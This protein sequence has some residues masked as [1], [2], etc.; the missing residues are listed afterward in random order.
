MG[1]ALAPGAVLTAAA[2]GCA[3]LRYADG[4]R[5]E[6]GPDTT[7]RPMPGSGKLLFLERGALKA[8]VARQPAGQPLVIATSNA[9]ARVLG[10]RFTLLAAPEATRLE[11][12][13]GKVRL[14]RKPDGASVDVGAG[15]FAQ[16]ARGTALLTRPLP[17]EPKTVFYEVEEFGTARGAKPADGMVR[18]LFLEPFDTASGGWCVSVPASGM[19]V[20]GDVRLPRGSWHLWVRYRDEPGTTRIAF[21]AFAG[22]QPIGQ[23]STPGRSRNWVW[24]RFTFA[25]GGG[26]LRITLRSGFEGVKAAPDLA[27]FRQSPYGALNRWDRICLTPDEGFTPE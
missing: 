24:K 12:R 22:G 19:E 1:Q 14:T 3:S 25:A 18:R 20:T 11:V 5:L 8:D 13:E 4:T 10:T 17:E 26:P 6:T 21:E 16:A 15:Q 2:D 27:D 9:E 7:L 23:A